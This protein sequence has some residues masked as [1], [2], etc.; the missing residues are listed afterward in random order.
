MTIV[1]LL[2]ESSYLTVL[3]VELQRQLNFVVAASTGVSLRSVVNYREG[4]RRQHVKAIVYACRVPAA[5]FNVQ[6]EGHTFT[7]LSSCEKC[8]SR[9]RTQHSLN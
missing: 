5:V 9:H 8:L 1:Y 4:S 6:M 2:S 3:I 7:H